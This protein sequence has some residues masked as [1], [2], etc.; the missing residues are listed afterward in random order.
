[1]GTRDGKDSV[2]GEAGG[3]LPARHALTIFGI[4]VL[5]WGTTLVIELFDRFG[6]GGNCGRRLGPACEEG[7]LAL[8]AGAPALI[9][10]ICVVAW[11]HGMRGWVGPVAAF[12]G[13]A[14]LYGSGGAALVFAVHLPNPGG[15]GRG[16]TNATAAVFFLGLFVFLLFG[17]L[18]RARG[19]VGAKGLV[20]ELFWVLEVLPE[21]RKQRRRITRERGV[22]AQEAREGRIVPR[23]GR[24]KAH[25]ALFVSE[26]LLA[27]AGGIVAGHAFVAATS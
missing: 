20:R 25:W 21:S 17:V 23:T 11:L 24:Q 1:M 6:A 26:A 15:A 5:Y 13:L 8:A 9:L 18:S 2:R 3:N 14:F 7:R 19:D 4:F 22:S 12:G 10:G 16:A 27:S